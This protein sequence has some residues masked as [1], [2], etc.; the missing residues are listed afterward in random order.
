MTR[1]RS[2]ACATTYSTFK[3]ESYQ[4]S[5][6]LHLLLSYYSVVCFSFFFKT[7]PHRF[8][9]DFI[10]RFVQHLQPYSATLQTYNFIRSFFGPTHE[11]FENNR[12]LLFTK[13]IFCTLLLSFSDKHVFHKS[14]CLVRR[15]R[16]FGTHS[17]THIRCSPL[18]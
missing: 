7:R 12:F 17:G 9:E 15:S 16:A 8:Q 13:F 18:L 5:L 10:F 6:R 4:I 3:L 14:T 2:T 1:R 11:L